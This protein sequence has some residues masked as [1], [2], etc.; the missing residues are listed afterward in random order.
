MAST[1]P[2]SANVA[3]LHASGPMAGR[4][5]AFDWRTTPL[6]PIDQW[7]P[8]VRVAV[9]LMLSSHF[10]ACLAIGPQLVMLFNDGFVPILGAKPDALGRSFKDVWSEAWDSIGPIAGKALTGESTFIEDFPLEVTRHG[11]AELAY[12][13][14]C[15]SPVRDAEGRV[16][17]MLDTVFET[18]GKVR[19]EQ[20]LHAFAHSLEA[21]LKTRTAD[22]DRMWRLSVDAMLV[23][24]ADGRVQSANPAASKLLERREMEVVGC[25]F[26]DFVHAKDQAAFAVRLHE[27]SAQDATF[28]FETRML[29]AGG[30]LKPVAWTGSFHEGATLA[31]GRDMSAEHDAADALHITER[32]LQQAQKM[33]SLGR[34]TGGVAHD[35]N[36]LLQVISGNLQL[37]AI[38]VASDARAMQRVTAALAGVERGAKLARSLLAFGRRQTLEPHVVKADAVVHGIDEMLRR[39]LGDSVELDVRVV[40]QLWNTFVD[41]TQLENA[42]LNLCINARDAMNDHGRVVIDIDNTVLDEDYA[43][44]HDPLRPGEYVMI[45]VGDNGTGMS[46]EVIARAF[47]PFFSTKEEGKGT[48][49]GLSMVF[50]FVRQS[51]GHVRIDSEVGQGTTVR[52]YL[53]RTRDAREDARETTVRPVIGGQET[54]LVVEDDPSVRATAIDLLK[55]LG[56][57]ILKASDA[58][59]ALAIIESGI[60]IDLLFSDVVMPGPMRSVEMVSKARAML[61]QLAVLYTSGYVQ[62][63]ALDGM[64]LDA[65]LDLLV[66]PYTREQLGHKIRRAILQARA[67]AN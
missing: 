25:P 19:G 63:A 50:G 59:R 10:P 21:E 54:V 39:A 4:I 47:E 1:Q 27:L 43:R 44:A 14:F 30:R 56:Y 2:I 11:F 24:G 7:D 41:V 31:I 64:T 6:G 51:G 62:D 57:R 38:D 35:F 5:R 3:T 32:A 34:L 33:E 37:L 18:S 13:T 42:L 15:Y 28:R 40:P 26:I 45:A 20:K 17:G 12:F 55:G 48:G 22:R 67:S 9:D 58:T 29:S 66:K 16:I 8:S 52:I 53:P 65:D 60:P 23:I 36:N 49:L 61:P 46:P